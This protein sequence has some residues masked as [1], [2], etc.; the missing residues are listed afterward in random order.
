MSRHFQGIVGRLG[1]HVGTEEP[2]RGALPRAEIAEVPPGD[3]LDGRVGEEHR[4]EAHH[5]RPHVSMFEPKR[6]AC[7]VCVSSTRAPGTALPAASST[8]TVASAFRCR[9][10]RPSA[11][12]H[13]SFSGI[14][15][16][17]GATGGSSRSQAASMYRIVML[18]TSDHESTRPAAPGQGDGMGSQ[19]AAGL[20]SGRSDRSKP[21]AGIREGLYE[22]QWSCHN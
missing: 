13:R 8:V 18:G 7:R 11:P 14:W 21:Y 12:A 15:P 4:V 1:G 3:R 2:G 16:A 9:S 20:A 10:I 19:G 6:N 17:E 5:C 22:S